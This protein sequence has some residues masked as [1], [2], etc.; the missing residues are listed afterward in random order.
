MRRK[1]FIWLAAVLSAVML[2]M[3]VFAFKEL[4]NHGR[5]ATTGHVVWGLSA[6][7]D[8]YRPP[9]GRPEVLR[10]IL[11]AAT[12]DPD[13]YTLDGWGHPVVVEV[14]SAPGEPYEY[15]ITSYGRDGAPGPCWLG[16]EC[17]TLDADWII[18]NGDF[19][20]P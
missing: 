5:F 13:D 20:E 12:L 18:E 8:T 1:N 19:L 7:V 2:G 9:S 10:E 14:L 6:I 3:S 15:R 17:D 4:L 11:I 16:P